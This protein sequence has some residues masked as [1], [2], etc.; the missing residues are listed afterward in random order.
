MEALEEPIKLD[1]ENFDKV[2]EDAPIILVDF[3]APWCGPCKMVG[4]VLEELSKEYSGKIWIGKLNTDDYPEI[5]QKYGA[6]SIPTFW[7]FKWGKPVG[8]FVGAYPKPAFVD[9]F[10]KLID[11]KPEDLE[12]IN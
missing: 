11:L 7:A 3:W 4:P 6:T 1:K 12:E 2:I 5:A 10:K 8:R 9:V